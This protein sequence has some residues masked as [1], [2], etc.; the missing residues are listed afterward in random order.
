MQ[1][2]VVLV[3]GIATQTPG[4]ADAIVARLTHRVQREVAAL[5]PQGAA[6]VPAEALL[7]VSR[8]YWGDVLRER[9]RLL[10]RMLEAGGESFRA[11]APWWYK[12]LHLWQYAKY[13]W[14]KNERRFISEYIGDVIGYLE[15]G[16]HAAVHQRLTDSLEQLAPADDRAEGKRPLTIIAHSLGTVISSDYVW[17][18]T[19]ARRAEGREGFHDRWRFD[20]FFTL[21]SPMALFSLKYGGPEAFKQ[22]IAVESPQGRWI[23]LFD[24]DDPIGMPLKALND[25]YGRAVHQ[26]VRV[27]AGAYLLA[28]GGYFTEPQ[29]LAILSRKLALDWAAVNQR[30]P[31]DRLARLYAAYDQAP[32]LPTT[33]K[34]KRPLVAEWIDSQ[35]HG[36]T[37]GGSHG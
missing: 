19:K 32:G 33:R 14:R 28:H 24:Q 29:T 5:L 9:Q 8:V 26:D 18:R 6:P 1:V 2:G 30:L 25:A 27:D 11:H 31:A 21:G 36:A 20:N 13:L 37:T 12:T 15:P 35:Q 22:P 17:D 4:W 16:A 10:R 3:H 34:M 23:N 7:A